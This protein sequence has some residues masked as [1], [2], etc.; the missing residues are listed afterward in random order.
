MSKM[1]GFEPS[2]H[3]RS[4]ST[5]FSLSMPFRRSKNASD[6]TPAKMSLAQVKLQVEL[7]FQD[8]EGEEV[9]RMRYKVR[10]V[11]DVKE[12][13]ML[14][15]DIHQLISRRHSQYVAAERINGLLPCFEGW[16]PAKSMAKI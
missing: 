14:R 6:A 3:S 10:S 5:S 12:L 13:W 1:L 2:D 7:S 9:D 8:L 4:P 16:I 15:S 11:R